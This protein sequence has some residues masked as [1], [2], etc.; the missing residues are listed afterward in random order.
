MSLDG[1]DIKM[2]KGFDFYG[3]QFPF[4][5][6]NSCK[7]CRKGDF[8][9]T[10]LDLYANLSII[11]QMNN[12]TFAVVGTLVES[13][14]YKLWLPVSNLDKGNLPNEDMK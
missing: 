6:D 2:T 12:T 8:A 11:M 14:K 1:R 10:K 7:Y 3:S 5:E 13:L 9:N 4:M